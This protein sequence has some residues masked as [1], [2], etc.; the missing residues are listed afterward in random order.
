MPKS[1]L[2][3][4]ATLFIP[5]AT[6]AAQTM[7]VG[8]GNP[9]VD[10]P[11]VQAAVDHGGRV[12]LM[13]HFSF[14][15]APTTPAGAIYPRMVTVTKEATIVGAIENDQGGGAV[16]DRGYIDR[17]LPHRRGRTRPAGGRWNLRRHLSKSQLSHQDGPGAA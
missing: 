5:A 12:M 3:V 8:T 13:G 15:K 9:D 6:M 11:A 7:V 1:R 16:I 14:D 17:K 2:A 10:V 4:I